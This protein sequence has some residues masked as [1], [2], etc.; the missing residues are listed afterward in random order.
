MSTEK[1]FSDIIKKT[2]EDEAT[3]QFLKSRNKAQRIYVWNWIYRGFCFLPLQAVA[4]FMFW[5]VFLSNH[6]MFQNPED[7]NW[8]GPFSCS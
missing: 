8:F 6:G 5:F 3:Y 1:E 4:P 2:Q 7:I